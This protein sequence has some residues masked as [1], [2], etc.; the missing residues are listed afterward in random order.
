MAEEAEQVEQAE[1]PTPD[2]PKKKGRGKLLVILLLLVLLGGGGGAAWYLGFVPLGATAPADAEAAKP[3]HETPQVG[4]LQA[5]DPFIANLE[6]EDGKRYLKA[7][8]QLEFFEASAPEE[9]EARIPQLRDL[10]LTLFTSKTY[11]EI[12]TPDGKAALRDDI[13][14]RV[15][16][17]LGSDVVKAVYFTEFIVQ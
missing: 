1:V 7:T 8:L 13:I 16:R 11:S 15:N 9:F 2:S 12:R 10:L 5:F 14:N 4:A 6:D 17:T 3:V